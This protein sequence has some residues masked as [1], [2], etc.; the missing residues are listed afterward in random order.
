MKIRAHDACL[1]RAPYKV[2][3]FSDPCNIFRG[4][5]LPI[6]ATVEGFYFDKTK[7]IA[8]IIL[9]MPGKRLGITTA[10]WDKM[11]EARLATEQQPTNPLKPIHKIM[12]PRFAGK[13]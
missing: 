9:S 7:N 5:T 2:V 8:R 6:Q 4:I 3:I 12:C 11:I 13:R 1:R 10:E